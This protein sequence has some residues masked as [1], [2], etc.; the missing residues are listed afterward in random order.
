MVLI[1]LRVCILL[2]RVLVESGYEMLLSQGTDL[3]DGIMRSSPLYNAAGGTQPA[4]LFDAAERIN[5]TY[6]T[7]HAHCTC[8]S[9]KPCICLASNALSANVIAMSHVSREVSD[10]TAS[11][12]AAYMFINS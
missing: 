9:H 1:V 2:H 6:G 3:V 8:S 7:Q 11:L 5:I 4:E 10:N 12:P